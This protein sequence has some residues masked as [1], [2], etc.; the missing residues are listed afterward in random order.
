KDLIGP[1]QGPAE[2]LLPSNLRDRY[3]LGQLVP[4]GAALSPDEQEGIVRGADGGAEEGAAEVETLQSPTL[5]PSSMGVT[6][7]VEGHARTIEV[8][9]SWGHYERVKSEV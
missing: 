8:I 6:F 2:E 9:A 3:L 4:R 7:C 5:A 1:A